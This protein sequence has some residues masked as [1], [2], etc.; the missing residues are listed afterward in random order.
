MLNLIQTLFGHFHSTRRQTRIDTEE[1]GHT[2]TLT[3]EAGWWCTEVHRQDRWKCIQADT[4]TGSD[5]GKH[6]TQKQA[7]SVRQTD[8]ARHKDTI[9]GGHR[10][11]SGPAIETNHAAF[12]SSAHRS[13][14]SSLWSREN[15]CLAV[16]GVWLGKQSLWGSWHDTGR[17]MI[18]WCLYKE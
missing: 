8:G 13:L 3:D 11:T 18:I 12:D 14:N 4:Q 17:C 9:I 10:Q 1:D 15:F 7:C 5:T 2:R 16:D 6:V